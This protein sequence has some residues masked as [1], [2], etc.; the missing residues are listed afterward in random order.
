MNAYFFVYTFPN[1]ALHIFQDIFTYCN[2]KAQDF[3]AKV[4]GFLH[5]GCYEC[6]RF[7]VLVFGL[8]LEDHKGFRFWVLGLGVW[9]WVALQTN[10]LCSEVGF[11][12]RATH[13]CQFFWSK[14]RRFAPLAANIPSKERECQM[15]YV[16]LPTASN[17]IYQ[18]EQTNMPSASDKTCRR[19]TRIKQQ[20]LRA[21]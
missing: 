17:K 13:Y 3:P 5:V 9:F 4:G 18:R 6:V 20:K 11:M 8:N 1:A 14:A 12:H 10:A 16:S 7:W 21:L 19:Q 15:K 2:M